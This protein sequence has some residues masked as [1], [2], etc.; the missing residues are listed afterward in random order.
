MTVDDGT[1]VISSSTVIV[2]VGLNASRSTGAG[3]SSPSHYTSSMI[4][5]IVVL[6]VIVVVTVMRLVRAVGTHEDVAENDALRVGCTI[7]S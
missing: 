6:L 3:P 1:I 2:S 7:C 4:E 5:L